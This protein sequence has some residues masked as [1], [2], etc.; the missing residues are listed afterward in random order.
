MVS[1]QNI[2]LVQIYGLYGAEV[3]IWG[4]VGGFCGELGFYG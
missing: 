2:Q 3:V 1:Y 4:E